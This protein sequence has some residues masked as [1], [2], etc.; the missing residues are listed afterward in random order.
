MNNQKDLAND[1][2]FST[3]P[4]GERFRT[5]VE[6]INELNGNTW[7]SESVSSGTNASA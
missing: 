6:E 2:N 7:N 3:F 4:A 1:P 5:S